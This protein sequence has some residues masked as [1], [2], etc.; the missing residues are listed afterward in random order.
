MCYNIPR[1]ITTGGRLCFIA[2]VRIVPQWCPLGTT[3]ATG[4]GQTRATGSAV[5]T[6][7][8]MSEWGLHSA[9]SVVRR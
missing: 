5:E 6:P 1:T 4:V 2:E 3:I 9:A 7:S 8:T